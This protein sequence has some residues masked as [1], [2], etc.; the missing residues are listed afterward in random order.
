MGWAWRG[1]ILDSWGWGKSSWAY[2]KFIILCSLWNLSEVFPFVLSIYSYI[3]FNKIW[4]EINFAKTEVSRLKSEHHLKNE[5][6]SYNKKENPILISCFE[7]SKPRR[8]LN[9]K[10][11][12]VMIYR[13]LATRVYSRKLSRRFNWNC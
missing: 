7:I 12:S 3:N 1:L 8:V 13:F 5:Q 2:Q 6:Q 11:D 4:P 9:I 10:S